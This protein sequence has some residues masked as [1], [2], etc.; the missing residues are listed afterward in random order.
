MGNETHSYGAYGLTLNAPMRLPELECLGVTVGRADVNV[1]FGSCGSPVPGGEARGYGQ[2]L[3]ADGTRLFWKEAGHFLVSGGREIVIDPAPMAEEPFIR[4][5]LLGP[6]L[7]A[8]LH[9]RGFVVLHASGIAVNGRAVAF[10]AD[11]GEGKSTTAAAFHRAGC[12]VIAD[13]LMAVRVSDGAPE[14]E[15]GFPQLKLL[16]DAL[17]GLG[18]DPLQLPIVHTGEDKRQRRVSGP[19]RQEPLPLHALYVLSTAE[20]LEISPVGAAAALKALARLTF[21][22]SLLG[23]VRIREHFAQCASLAQM[24]VVRRLSRPRDL[25]RLSDIVELVKADVAASG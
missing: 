5:A 14:V 7:A 24:G 8:L 19:A 11:S 25:S 12:P 4:A 3:S 20:S 23:P 22:S 9:Q 18:E 16:P 6:V 10:M 17:I 15:V 2:E 13:D 1:R 21:A